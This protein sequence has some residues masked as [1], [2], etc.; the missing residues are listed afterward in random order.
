MADF[1]EDAVMD[2]RAEITKE[3]LE[4][5]ANAYIEKR[6]ASSN[7]GAQFPLVGIQRTLC[8][9]LMVAFACEVVLGELTEIGYRP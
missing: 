1:A 4:A 7:S 5:K 8:V 2:G 3:A 6:V 9:K